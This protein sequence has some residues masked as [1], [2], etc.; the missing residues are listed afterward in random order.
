[1]AFIDKNIRYLEEV[2]QRY[3]SGEGELMLYLRRQQPKL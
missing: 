1:M 3:D 2:L